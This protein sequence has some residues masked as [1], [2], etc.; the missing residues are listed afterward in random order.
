M[1]DPI[2]TPLFTSAL[3][4]A[5]LP[6][7]F[8]VGTATINIAQVLS[9]ATV[10]AATVG[11]S[12][13]LQPGAPK[14]EQGTI[15][16][17][18][19]VPPRFAGFGEVRLAGAYVLYETVSRVSHDIVAL[20]QGPVGGFK[21]IYLSDT[22][23]D[24][25]DDGQVQEFGEGAYAGGV[26]TIQARPGRKI[27]AAYNVSGLHG[28]DID[29]WSDAHRGDRI[30]SLY[31]VSTPVDAGDFQRVYPD[32]VPKPSAA[33][34]LPCWDFRDVTQDADDPDTWID[35]DEWDDA[36]AYVAGDR[37]LHGGMLIPGTFG[38]Q[39]GG[40]LYIALGS[41]TGVKPGTDATK[42]V[43]VWKNPV[44][45]FVTY[46]MSTDIGMGLAR[47]RLITPNIAALTVEAAKCDEAV[48]K[49]GGF[50]ARY[51]SNPW[52]R[53]DTNPEEVLGLILAACEGWSGLDGNG[54]LALRV[55]VYEAPDA[56]V[57]LTEDIILDVELKY[58]PD[59]ESKIDELTLSYTSPEHDYTAQ[60]VN[61]WRN[62]DAILNRGQIRSKAFGPLSV[63]SFSQLRRLSKAMMLRAN[64]LKGTITTNLGGL[65]AAGERYVPVQF[66]DIP[67]LADAVVEIRT[68]RTS[69]RDRRVTYE[70]S[71]IDG[72]AMYAWTPATEEGSKPVWP[73]PVP[74]ESLDAVL[75]DLAAEVTEDGESIRID[76]SW[77]HATLSSR[78]NV[79]YVI[80][81]RDTSGPGRWHYERAEDPDITGF[82]ISHSFI[83]EIQPDVFQIQVALLSP[84]LTRG[85]FSDPIEV[86]LH[87]DALTSDNDG[88][89]IL[90][91]NGALLLA[92]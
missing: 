39:V 52:Y 27:E 68:R 70:F 43:A 77:A 2:I 8:A 11:A 57:T 35:Y 72:A 67:E 25:N 85:E 81:Y 23:I 45:Q 33:L 61:P 49:V 44:L 75:E 34:F 16:L 6:T 54:G 90:D 92:A 62:E 24:L 73:A 46:L 21:K 84:A 63:Q 55:G 66:S 22:A 86:T 64:A 1:Q 79:D 91:N 31:A 80:R 58:S 4:G 76:A 56:A 9:A 41:S 18:Q 71:I 13:L 40:M 82:T 20:C 42:W 32:G 12:V 3:I 83:A 14:V 37:V 59:D 29:V 65:I 19:T 17:K 89:L 87:D 50:E 51:Q 78:P 38:P 60:E 10:L 74:D 7:S 47:T 69:F 26:V 36:T 88:D 48:A 5:G 53:L 15:A 28:S 30:A